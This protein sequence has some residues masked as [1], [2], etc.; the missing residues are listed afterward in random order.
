MIDAIF[1]KC[2]ELLVFLANQLG[3][4]YE[5]INV[6]IFVII[7]PIFT[8]ALIALVILQQLKIRRLLGQVGKQE[9]STAARE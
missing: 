7:W 8:L 2:V 4:T 6:W 9:D 3:M 5:A 1:D